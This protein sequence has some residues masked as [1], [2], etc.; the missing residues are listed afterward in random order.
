MTF[1]HSEK[2]RTQYGDTK[3]IIGTYTNSDGGTGG[4]IKLGIGVIR[5]LFFV[6]QQTGSAVTSNAPVVDETFPFNGNSVTIV[7][8]ANADGI[9]FAVAI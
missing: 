3:I 5:V 4:E 8:D 7:T 1:V 6:L 2:K 9:Y